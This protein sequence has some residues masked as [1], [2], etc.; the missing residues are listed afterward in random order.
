V[1]HRAL[2]TLESADDESE[3]D[4]FT[5]EQQLYNEVEIEKCVLKF[6]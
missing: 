2:K 4:A 5:D 3:T 1:T 6:L